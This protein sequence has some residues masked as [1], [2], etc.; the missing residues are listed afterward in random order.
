MPALWWWNL[1]AVRGSI[2]VALQQL[3]RVRQVRDRGMRRLSRAIKGKETS[4]PALPNMFPS[5]ASRG[6][7]IRTG[8]VSMIAGAP[9]AGK[10]MLALALA[11]RA[12]VPTMY[13][14]ADSHMH[15][16]SMRLISMDTNTDQS[17]VEGVMEDKDWASSVLRSRDYMWWNFSSNPTAR[18]IS[19]LVDAHIELDGNPPSLFI[20]DN[21]TDCLVDGDEFGGMRGF[22]KD[23]K[24]LAR[25][26]QMA[27]VVLHH[28]SEGVTV[29]SGHCPPRFSLQGKVAQTPALV[30]TVTNEAGFLGVCPV[31]NRYGASNASGN[32]VT[33]FTYDPNRCLVSELQGQELLHA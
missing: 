2:L 12:Q 26:H 4:A 10:S 14:S 30:I 22:L 18:M 23:M 33:W 25:E 3:F 8:E 17:V 13:L 24:F 28:T 9:A 16:Q 1:G 15:T 7:S 19:E 32:E 20:V 6:I 29:P 21:L 5:L 11:V 27:M 31:K